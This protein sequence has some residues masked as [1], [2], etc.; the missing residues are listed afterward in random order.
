[1]SLKYEN[2]KTMGIE[3]ST[4]SE[5]A[6]PGMDKS[7]GQKRLGECDVQTPT[8]TKPHFSCWIYNSPAIQDEKNRVQNLFS[9]FITTVCTTM[10]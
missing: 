4:K 1:M 7:Q 6:G 2:I 9:A 10:T 8:S 3:E 5:K